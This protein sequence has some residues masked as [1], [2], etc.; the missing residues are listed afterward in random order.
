MF[1]GCRLTV[2]NFGNL[3]AGVKCMRRPWKAESADGRPQGPNGRKIGHEKWL[4]CPFLL[5][6][7]EIA[8]ENTGYFD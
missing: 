7:S 5:G 8:S 1:R 4:I 2:P 6:A 3:Q